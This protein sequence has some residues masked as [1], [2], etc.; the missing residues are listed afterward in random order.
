MLLGKRP[1]ANSSVST[2][3]YTK[4]LEASI[5]MIMINILFCTNENWIQSAH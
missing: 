1:P 5:K 2:V 4:E 3:F